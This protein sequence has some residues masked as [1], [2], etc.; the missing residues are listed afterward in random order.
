L[1]FV[2]CGSNTDTPQY[3]SPTENYEY[4]SLVGDEPTNSTECEPSLQNEPP[5]AIDDDRYDY[6]TLPEQATEIDEEVCD[7]YPPTPIVL[8][9]PRVR[10]LVEP[11]WSFN[12]VFPFIEGMAAVEYYDRESMGWDYEHILGYI[13][14]Q[15]EIVIPVIHRHWPGFYS[16]RGAPPFSHGLVAV[17]SNDHGGVGI[18][19]TYGNL[20]VPFSFS[21]AWIF[22]EG[23]MAVRAPSVQDEEGNWSSS[24]WGFIDITGELVIDF[25]FRYAS[26]FR[27]GR[28]AVLSHYGQWG[29]IDQ[30]GELVIPFQFR[31]LSG[32]G[33]GFFLPRFS[34][35]LAAVN[36]GEDWSWDGWWSGTDVL[37]GYID[38]YGEMVIPPIYREAWHFYNGFA[39][40]VHEEYGWGFIDR[41]G[42][43]TTGDSLFVSYDRE[44]EF[45]Q[46]YASWS[47]FSEG[48]SAVTLDKRTDWNA[49]DNRLW[50]F[51]DEEGN[52][53][54]PLE[55]NEVS[56]FYNGLA[57]VRQEHR[58]GIIDG[59]G[60]VVV[61]IDFDEIHGFSEGLAWVR[62]GRW[63][64]IIEM[65]G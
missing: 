57:W 55:F 53:I 61:P 36:I 17:Q 19:D 31:H 5:T 43:F 60:N 7:L 49:P 38:M 65:I 32:Q 45:Q 29:F 18:F 24:G 25:Q 62:Q 13:N 21:D 27:E 10:W 50:G 40:I 9:D 6:P 41:E 3:E 30:I 52:V 37:W 47:N 1:L 59:D 28:A 2:G 33:D 51:I 8:T 48:L 20:I 54:V 4:P 14:R 26:A 39:N 22:S 64:G 42:N 35:G 11:I 46:A 44:N 12:A 23:L 34:E 63:W 58:W 15:G 16:H 56:D